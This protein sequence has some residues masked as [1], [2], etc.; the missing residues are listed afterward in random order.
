MK[1][2]TVV[3]HDERTVTVDGEQPGHDVSCLGMLDYVS[4]QL[5]RRREDELLGGDFDRSARSSSTGGSA[6]NQA[7]IALPNRRR[8]ASAALHRAPGS[9]MHASV[10]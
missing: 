3:L 7:S 6:S 5:P 9:P 4:E 2:A 10:R 1:D 8:D